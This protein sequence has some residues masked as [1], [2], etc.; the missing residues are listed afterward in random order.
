YY[1]THIKPKPQLPKE[2]KQG[3]ICKICGYLHEGEDLPGDFICP[4][5]K[6]G[7]NDFDKI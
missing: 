2:A 4:L 1:F 3:F 5:C 7:A 6:H